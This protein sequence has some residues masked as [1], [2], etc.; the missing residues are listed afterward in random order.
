MLEGLRVGEHAELVREVTLELTITAI[1]ST[2]PAVLST[3]SM[4]LLMETA[5]AE[6][7]L[8]HLP[9]GFIS[10]GV[11]VQVRHLAPTPLGE[12]VTA[13]ATIREVVANL[14]RFDVELHDRL[15]LVGQGTHDRAVIDVERFQRGLERRLTAVRDE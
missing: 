5:A 12:Q 7:I 11:D 8:P 1:K 4:I 10:V 6:L 2:L 9:A 15:Q 13:R 14:V 3:P